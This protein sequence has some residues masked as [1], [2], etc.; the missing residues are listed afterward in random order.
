MR[1]NVADVL[2]MKY[3]QRGVS[4]LKVKGQKVM[5]T[6]EMLKLQA[7]TRIVSAIGAVY[8]LLTILTNFLVAKFTLLCP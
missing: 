2:S 5:C 3:I 4:Q 8:M 7:R 1:S 6:S